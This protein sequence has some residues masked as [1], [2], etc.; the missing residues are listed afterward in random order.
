MDT[1]R[2]RFILGAGSTLAAASLPASSFAADPFP[3]RPIK[4]VVPFAPGGATDLLARPVAERMARV[5]GQPVVVEN[6]TGASGVIGAAAVV[7][8]PADAYTLYLGGLGFNVLLPLIGGAEGGFD[9]HQ[10]LA[11]VSLVASYGPLLVANPK[12]AIRTAADVIARAKSEKGV[13]YGTAGVT[14]STYLLMEVLK[15]EGQLNLINAPYRGELPAMQDVA[16]GNCDLAVVS[17]MAARPLI[18]AGRL[19]PVMALYPTRLAA[20][21]DLPSITEFYPNISLDPWFG[22]FAR[23]G[24]PAAPMEY[25][26]RVVTDVLADKTVSAMLQERGYVL[27][28]SGKPQAFA[29]FLEQESQNWKSKL[30]R[31]KLLKAGA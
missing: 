10:A 20:M 23:A 25:L 22:F 26:A 18:E 19:R 29:S 28:P 9:P 11:P 8:A 1:S 5:M 6:L 2:R 21:P 13:T 31:A 4:I 3:S 7:R 12:S 27:R 17:E 30:G 14:S 24:T 15:H 16:S